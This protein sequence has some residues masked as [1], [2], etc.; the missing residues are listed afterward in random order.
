MDERTNNSI[1]KKGRKATNAEMKLRQA[2]VYDMVIKGATRPFILR[3]AAREWG[4]SSRS[5]DN[6][7][8]RA[9]Q[10]IEK[11]FGEK[12]RKEKLTLQLARLS[13][14]YVKNYTIEDYRECRNVI[15]TENKLLGLNEAEKHDVKVEATRILTFNPFVEGDETNNGTT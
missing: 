2:T 14:L 7:L 13:D 3:Y 6:L 10:D 12:Y 9:K 4:I 15:E 11:V 1:E 8:A 5:V